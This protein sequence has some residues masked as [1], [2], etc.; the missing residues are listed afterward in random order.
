[1]NKIR[2]QTARL[3]AIAVILFLYGISWLPQLADAERA[4]LAAGFKFA[5][6]PLPELSGYEYQTIRNVHPE[7]KHIAGWLSAMGASVA[8]NDLDGDGLPNDVCHIDIRI[9]QVIL[10]PV[11]ET[12]DRYDPFV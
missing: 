2:A 6:T 5:S 7:L 9:D 1:M 11:P 8:L 3:T 4:V 10:S 12:P